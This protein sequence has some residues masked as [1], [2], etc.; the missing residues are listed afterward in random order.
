MRVGTCSYD[1]N[2]AVRLPLRGGSGGML[3]M[4]PNANNGLFRLYVLF[5]HF[6]PRDVT[7]GN[8]R[9]VFC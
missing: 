5:S 7:K 8:F 4:L 3:P 6:R 1:N 9:F 2:A